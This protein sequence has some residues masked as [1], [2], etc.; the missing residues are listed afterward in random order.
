MRL[1]PAQRDRAAG[2]LVGTAAADALGA[3]Y[4]FGPPLTD[5][6]VMH[7]GKGWELGEWTDDTSM[8]LAVATASAAGRLDPTEIAANF[9]SWIDSGPKNVG[10]QSGRVLRAAAGDPAR[11][12]A[13]AASYFAANPRN[14]AGNGSLMRSASVALSYLGDDAAIMRA[15]REESELTHADPVAAQACIIWSIAID[16]AVREG[17]LDGVREGV[18]A[19]EDDDARKDWGSLLDWNR[20]TLVGQSSSASLKRFS[21]MNTPAQSSR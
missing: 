3:P 9:I 13:E 7:A 21:R 17:R 20:V 6:P 2:V 15:A 10:I 18:A 5:R 1:L 14:S 4:E 19:L 8:A 11:V 16:R 12:A